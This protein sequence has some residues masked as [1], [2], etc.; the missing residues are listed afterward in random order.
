M[1]V[2][3]AGGLKLGGGIFLQELGLL[4]PSAPQSF[5][6]EAASASLGWHCRVFMCCSYKLCLC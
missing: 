1:R 3:G 5:L 4:E 2:G 6:E